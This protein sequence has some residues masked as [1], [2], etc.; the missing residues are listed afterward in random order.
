MC[1]QTLVVMKA[2][3]GLRDEDGFTAE[4]SARQGGPSHEYVADY[5]KTVV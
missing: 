3:L 1:V 5:L 2:D 4:E